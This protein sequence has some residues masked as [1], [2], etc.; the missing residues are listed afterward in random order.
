[1]EYFNSRLQQYSGRFATNPKHNFFF[2]QFIIEKKKVSDSIYIALKKVHSQCVIASQLRANPHR[3]VNVTCE[4]QAYLF[5]RQI[6]G[7]PC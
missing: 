5:Q 6:P 3:L 1:M 2:A 7:T 4:D